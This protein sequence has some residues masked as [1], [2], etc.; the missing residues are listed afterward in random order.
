MT[1]GSTIDQ[2]SAEPSPIASVC[3]TTSAQFCSYFGFK[4]AFRDK[5]QILN[6]PIKKA[7]IVLTAVA[8][9]GGWAVLSN[10][11]DGSKQAAIIAWRAGAIQ[12]L[13]AGLLTFLNIWLLERLYARIASSY[14]E[15]TAWLLTFLSAMSLQYTVIIPVHWLNQTPNILLTL[16][17]GLLIGSIFSYLYL[18][19]I[20]RYKA[21]AQGHSKD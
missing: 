19:S 1:A 16:L 4:P 12:G 2:S 11:S 10:L 6:T 3:Q 5:E 13:Y 21:Y 14:S 7:F 17:P 9:Y 15:P 8:G 20:R 18:M